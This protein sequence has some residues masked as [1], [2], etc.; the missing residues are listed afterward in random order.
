MM[1]ALGS[2]TM[3][4]RWGSGVRDVNSGELSYPLVAL[5]L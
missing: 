2:P 1:P 5:G 3:M 4:G